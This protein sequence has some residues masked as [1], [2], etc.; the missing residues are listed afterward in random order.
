LLV[1]GGGLVPRLLVDPA[2]RAV[3]GF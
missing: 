1:L 3:A 2:L